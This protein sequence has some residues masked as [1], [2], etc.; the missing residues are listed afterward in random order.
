MDNQLSLF[1]EFNEPPQ[2][3]VAEEISSANIE[4]VSE[5]HTRQSM[6]VSLLFEYEHIPI[7]Q[8]GF[9][10]QKA[11]EIHWLL[12]RTNEA[13]IKIGQCLIEVKAQLPHGMFGKWIE[14]EFGMSDRSARDFMNIAQRLNGKSAPG[15]D[16]GMRILRELSAPSTPDEVIEGVISGEIQPT[17]E[18]IRKV[19][20]ELLL[21]QQESRRHE[22]N[23][24]AASEQLFT[25]KQQSQ[26]EIE[27]L[28][29]QVEDEMKGQIRELEAKLREIENTPLP[30]PEIRTI[31]KEVVP[32]SVK[33]NIESLQR[34]ITELQTKV[35]A[36][37]K[38]IPAE[39]QK[40]IESLQKQMDALRQ[41]KEK[42]EEENK[43]QKERVKKLD[44]QLGIAVKDR[45]TSE[46]DERIRQEWRS[47]T[48]Q[49]RSSLMRLLGGWPTALDVNS[50]ES[51]DWERLSQL[52]T[53][54]Q[55][56][57]EE[58]DSLHYG[59]SVDDN[60]SA[61]PVAYIVGGE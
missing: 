18:D 27:A 20:R 42:L 17:F 10:L 61:M 48:S 58:C 28:T 26:A 22:A 36:E 7:A 39:T 6:E 35:E 55:R 2:E 5:G 44:Q 57:L 12:K 53:T 47:I 24:L 32:L 31:E 16:L 56:V 11:G 54:L 51:D 4:M 1:A 49:A 59:M 8:R 14:G 19:K 43:S 25:V 9:V 29:K 34:R 37:K 45:I 38:T 21:T 50:F 46:N 41:N 52:K 3:N 40:Q 33:N 13:I 15:A 30:I 23:A 60:M